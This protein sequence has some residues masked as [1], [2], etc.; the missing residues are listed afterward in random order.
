MAK[1]PNTIVS[2]ITELKGK[3]DNATIIAGDFNISLSATKRTRE[4]GQ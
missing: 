3:T 4:K 2:K 1:N